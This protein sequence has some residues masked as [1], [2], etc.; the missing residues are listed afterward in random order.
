VGECVFTF[1]GTQIGTLT[2]GNPAKL[3]VSSA[4]IPRTGGNFLC[5]SSGTWTGSYTVNTPSSLYV[6]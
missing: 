5:G 4:K 6:D 2:S 3:D 1:N